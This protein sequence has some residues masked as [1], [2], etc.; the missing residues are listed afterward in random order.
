MLMIKVKLVKLVN[1]MKNQKEKKLL[2][3]KDFD[4]TISINK[5]F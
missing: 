4:Y 2:K 1:W 5:D 3:S